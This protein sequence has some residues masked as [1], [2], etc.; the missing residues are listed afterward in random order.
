MAI[1]ASLDIEIRLHL[2]DIA[3]VP[4]DLVVDTLKAVNDAVYASEVADLRS[5]REEC[6]ELPSVAL[7]ARSIDCA[8]SDRRPSAS[9]LLIRGHSRSPSW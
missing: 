5:W 8:S 9:G 4:A 7:D 3:D 2:S 1:N 6:P